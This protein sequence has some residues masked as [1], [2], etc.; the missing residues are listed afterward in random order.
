MGKGKELRDL[1]GG[2]WEGNPTLKEMYNILVNAKTIAMVGASSNP[3]R[4]SYEV[5]QVL[6]KA[7]YHVIPVNPNE[8]E[9]LGEKAYASLSDIPEPVDIV[10]VFR[11]AESTPPVAEEAVKI[12]AKVLW[13]QLGIINEEAAE[14]ARKGGL[15]VVMDR[16]IKVMHR[17]LNVPDKT[18]PA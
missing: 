4:P 18:G 10:D 11:R 12:G 8:T 15:Q 7:G 14:I 17:K 13:L 6:Q 16:C 2:R 1:T 9:V 5:M 3:D